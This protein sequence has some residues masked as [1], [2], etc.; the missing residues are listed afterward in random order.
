MNR[1]LL[2]LLAA[3]ALNAQTL[4]PAALQLSQPNAKLVIGIDLKNLRESPTGKSLRAQ[5]ESQMGDLQQQLGQ[6]AGPMAQLGM[7]APM[8]AQLVNDIDYVLI[9]SPGGPAATS[10]NAQKN[11]PFLAVVQGRVQTSLLGFVTMT[12][13]PQ[14]YGATNIYQSPGT[15]PTSLAFLSQDILL[16]GDPASVR[17]AIDRQN[18][19]TSALAPAL[20]ARAN[21]MAATHDIWFAALDLASFAGGTGMASGPASEI[22]GLEIGLGLR[23]GMQFDLNL[24]TKTEASARQFSSLLAMGMAASGSKSGD[25][26][27]AELLNKL[28]VT[29]E[30][31]RLSIGLSLTEPEIEQYMR[32][33]QQQRN[34]ARRTNGAQVTNQPSATPAPPAKPGKI[35]IVG[36]DEGDREIEVRR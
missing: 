13:A 9:S 2:L 16:L 14:R 32:Y 33:A 25:P 15:T 23:G 31:T 30:G 24:N 36:L 18:G 35:R 11:P 19:T 21:Q 20:L 6:Q 17:A 27:T 3:F 29:T 5:L 7:F 8:L 28:R 26:Q 34:L 10:N 1:S 12:G 22:N 4:P